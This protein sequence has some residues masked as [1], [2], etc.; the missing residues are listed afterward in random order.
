MFARKQ[1]RGIAVFILFI[2][3]C[4]TLTLEYSY[5]Q[6][7]NQF[8][9]AQGV[10]PQGNP[11]AVE[12]NDAEPVMT[13]EKTIVDTAQPS[14]QEKEKPAPQLKKKKKFRWLGK[15][16]V[17]CI[18][19]G[20]AYGIAMLVKKKQPQATEREAT[21]EN[22]VLTVN[23]G[24][25][26]VRYELAS[27]PAGTFQ[28][29]SNSSEAY[30]DEKPVHTVRISKSFWLGKTEVTQGLWQ[31]VVDI[32][33][34]VFK[35]GDTYPVEAVSWDNCQAF[36]TK[37]NQMLGSNYF[38]LP[39]E[40]EWEYACRAGTTGDRYGNLDAIA[41]YD[42]NS[43]GTTHPVGQKQANAWGLY[44]TL[45]NVWEFCQDRYGDYSAGYQTDPT[46]PAS[47]ADRVDRGGGYYGGARDV[48]SASR[49]RLGSGCHSVIGFRLA[50][51]Q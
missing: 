9:K 33:P 44:D 51:V 12:K 31:A 47:G 37:L 26:E 7:E 14:F 2:F 13:K 24:S 3:T 48:R 23:K 39:T 38:R 46:G 19:A 8:P 25:K 10:S 22:G 27:I 30:S 6:E 34:S 18:I 32:N 5:S 50:R 20:A 11:S 41:W 29:G 43:S 35:S 4:F 16:L 1:F 28:M 17:L 42:S 15:I 21:F 45:G 36:I 40:A 49:S